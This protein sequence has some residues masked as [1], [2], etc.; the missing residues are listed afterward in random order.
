MVRLVVMNF[1]QSVIVMHPF[2]SVGWDGSWI[3]SKNFSSSVISLSQFSGCSS[4][5]LSLVNGL[6]ISRFDGGADREIKVVLNASLLSL[7][8]GSLGKP[9][10]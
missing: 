6:T 1:L 4:L 3:L 10:E 2:S 5:I 9:I 8:R 7:A